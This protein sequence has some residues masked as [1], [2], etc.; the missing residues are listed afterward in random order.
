VAAETTIWEE[1]T[2]RSETLLFH[3]NPSREELKRKAESRL[4]HEEDAAVAADT[5]KTLS[6]GPSEGPVSA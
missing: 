4:H 2:L 3:K 5:R 6:K 1:A